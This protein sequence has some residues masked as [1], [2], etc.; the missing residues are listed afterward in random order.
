[1]SVSTSVTWHKTVKNDKKS[2]HNGINGDGTLNYVTLNDKPQTPSLNLK[3][4]KQ[5][6]QQCGNVVTYIMFC[7]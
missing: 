7:E 3:K 2:W 5:K 6:K 1:M 4:N